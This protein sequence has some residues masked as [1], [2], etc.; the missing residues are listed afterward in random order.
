[1]RDHDAAPIAWREHGPADGPVV[2]LL[3]GLGGS[4][5]AWEPQLAALGEAG[6]RAVAWDL[7]GYGASAPPAGPLTFAL[8]ADA[9][10]T[11][12]DT[13][14][15]DCAPLVGLS[16]GGMVALHAAIRHPSR[17]RSLVVVD[18][19]PAFG[20]D[21]VTT[22]EG[23]IAARLAPLRAGATP[24]TMAPDLFRAIMG[25]DATEAM[26]TE[27]AAAMARISP[28]ALEAAVRCLPTHDVR[29]KLHRITCP[30][31]VVVGELDA[32]T[33]VAYAEHLAAHLPDARLLVIPGSGH[34][35]NLEAPDALN[36]ALLDFLGPPA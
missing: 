8:A 30:T 25:P 7:P 13:L 36:R 29:A 16:M 26:V 34:I 22:A 14:G 20:L 3:H 4:R 11:L 17:V 19:S 21:G 31:L 32:E 18:S 9:V 28:A 2:L 24:A 27:A 12:L 33:P 10:A 6:W 1:M 15:A 23:W 5:T 35:T